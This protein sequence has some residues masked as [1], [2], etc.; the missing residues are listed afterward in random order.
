MEA[1]KRETNELIIRDE[2]PE[3]HPEP[4]AAAALVERAGAR[5]VGVPSRRLRL[6]LPETALHLP[7]THKFVLLM[8]PRLLKV[9]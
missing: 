9:K 7:A 1:Y 3:H 2:H 5:M 8:P 6:N 4:S